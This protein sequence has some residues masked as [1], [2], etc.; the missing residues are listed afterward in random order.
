MEDL[1]RQLVAGQDLREVGEQVL[2][3]RHRHPSPGRSSTTATGTAP[4]RRSPRLTTAAPRTAG[5]RSSAA[6]TSSGR[7]LNPP[8]M[9]AWSA[10][11][12]MKRKPSA[13]SRARS[14]V[15]T[16]ASC[17]S[18]AALHLQQALGI[19]RHRFAGRLIDHP[20][21]A[22]G[23]RPADAAPLGRPDQFLWSS[24]F[25]PATPPPNSVAAYVTSTGMPYVGRERV[26]VVGV[27]RCRARH[28]R[29]DAGQVAG[30]E[31]GLEHHAQRRRDQ[32][33]RR[34]AVAAHRVGPG[35]DG[36]AFEQ[37][38]R[39]AVAHALQHAEEAAQMDQRGVDDG[40]AAPQAD[41]SSRFDS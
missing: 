23:M 34:R 10:R 26:G 1:G 30:I 40:D 41:V 14:V 3:S 9:I 27:E 39:A 19:G 32:A 12:R 18:W 28:D 11:P 20:Q 38:E 24:R 35:L 7:T 22:A 17:P 25:Q 21:L 37:A 5:C 31:I 33:G 4:R 8:R 13:S 2:A 29:A 36:E 6:L 16:Q 15:R